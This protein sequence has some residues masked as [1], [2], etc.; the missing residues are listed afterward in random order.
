MGFPIITKCVTPISSTDY[1]TVAKRPFN[2]VLSVNKLEAVFNMEQFYW[3]QGV[4][5]VLKQ[6]TTIK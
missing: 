1:T 2:S 3:Q 5:Y 6:M 4:D